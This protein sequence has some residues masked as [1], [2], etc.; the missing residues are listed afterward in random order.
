MANT[1]SY[2]QFIN[3]L[4]SY[5]VE[6]RQIIEK[7]E[8]VKKFVENS[9]SVNNGTKTAVTT[10][11]MVKTAAVAAAGFLFA[12]L[13]GGLSVTAANAALGGSIEDAGMSTFTALSGKVDG[14]IAKERIETCQADHEKSVKR[15]TEETNKIIEVVNQLIEKGVDVKVATVSTLAFLSHT[16]QSG[17]TTI[18]CTKAATTIEQALKTG[19]VQKILAP[20]GISITKKLFGG[21]SVTFPSV[22]AAK[23][24]SEAQ[25]KAFRLLA[26]GPEM[27]LGKTLITK[28][29]VVL[30]TQVLFMAADVTLVIKS[31]DTDHPLVAPIDTFISSLQASVE[32]TE[33]Q[34]AALELLGAK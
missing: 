17:S 4:K 19:E 18:D 2:E 33:N 16:G 7:L 13:T 5:A 29:K 9:S 3:A 28:G 6:G 14:K 27:L 30:T 12:P 21:L 22:K 25:S 20:T 26:Q 23:K 10:S 34:L 11:G 8:K 32:S 24:L 31:W 15:V 1:I